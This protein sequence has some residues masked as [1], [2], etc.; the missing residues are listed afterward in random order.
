M[1]YC[2]FDLRQCRNYVRVSGASNKTT[3]A[4]SAIAMAE[5]F[6]RLS[7]NGCGGAATKG[8]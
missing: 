5:G 4:L 3:G 8:M 1:R 2:P 7:P 6:D